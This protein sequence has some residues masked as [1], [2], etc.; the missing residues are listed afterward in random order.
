M[1][2]ECERVLLGGPCQKRAR[3]RQAPPTRHDYLIA[4]LSPIE[5]F[6]VILPLSPLD[7]FNFRVHNRHEITHISRKRALGT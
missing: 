2:G 6:L 3:A 7:R 5:L 1:M 4:F